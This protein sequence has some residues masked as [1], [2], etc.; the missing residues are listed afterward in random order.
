MFFRRFHNPQ[1]QL[2]NNSRFLTEKEKFDFVRKSVSWI[3]SRNIIDACFVLNFGY[4]APLPWPQVETNQM[5]SRN[6]FNEKYFD[7]VRLR[8]D[9]DNGLRLVPGTHGMKTPRSCTIVIIA[10][11]TK[12]ILIQHSFLKY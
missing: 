6:P 4:E 9:G 1:K 11:Q 2:T 7:Q 8:L 12:Y 3:E 10:G 5:C